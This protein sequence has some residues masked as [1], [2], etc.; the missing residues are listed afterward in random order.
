MTVP[1]MPARRPEDGAV[2]VTRLDGDFIALDSTWD[3]KAESLVVSEYNA[4]RL[5]GLLSLILGL[6]LPKK[7]SAAIKLG[8]YGP[9]SM[10]MRTPLPPNA[11]LGDR[12]AAAL[13]HMATVEELQK[14][15]YD[16]RVG[17]PDDEDT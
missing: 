6:H 14:Q 11:C 8:G 9:G 13:A 16:V 17:T 10:T 5:F 12:V 2:K 4:W 1:K 15:G 7:V 3:G